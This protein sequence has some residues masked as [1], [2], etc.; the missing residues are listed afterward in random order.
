MDVHDVGEAL[1]AGDHG[2]DVVGVYG[3]ERDLHDGGV[4]WV[5]PG[6]DRL[7]ERLDFG[8]QLADVF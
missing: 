4:V 7:D 3:I 5:G 8:E 1:Q 2:G 6:A